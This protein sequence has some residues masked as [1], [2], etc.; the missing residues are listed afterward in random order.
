MNGKSTLVSK[1]ASW[2]ASKGILCTVSAGNEGANTWK[3]ITAPADADSI[4]T[5]G[6]VNALGGLSSFSSIGPSFDGRTKPDI[7]AM[8]SSTVVGYIDGRIGISNGTS[9]SAPLIAGLAAGLIQAF[10]AHSAQQIRNGILKSGSQF[11]RADMLLGFGIPNFDKAS[12]SM[13]LILANEEE[14]KFSIY[15][16]PVSPGV[17]LHISTPFHSA[18]VEMLNN[19]GLIVHTFQLNQRESTIYLGP[20]VSG[21]YYFRFTTEST[22]LIKPVIIL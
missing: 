3:Y 18:Q 10:P 12:K 11:S 5:V 22:S 8:G 21:K 19:A 1:A 9:F 15:P 14:L 4:L 7:V 13:D 6:S 16:N 20:F 17:A 2:A